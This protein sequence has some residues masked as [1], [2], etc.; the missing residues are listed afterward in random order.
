VKHK[1]LKYVY[2]KYFR[3]GVGLAIG[4]V[5][6]YLALRQVNFKDVQTA[7]LDANLACVAWSLVSVAITN[8]AKAVRWKVLLGPG[9]RNVSLSHSLM[10]VLA[11]QALNTVYPAR[12]GDVSRAYLIGGRDFDRVYALGTIIL[13]KLLDMLFYALL[14][15]L[16]LVLVP[17]PDWINS[18]IFIVA[19]IA[20][21]SLALAF[22]LAYRTDWFVKFAQV[23][24]G[25]LPQ[26]LQEKTQNW[27][28]A[29]LSSLNVL[30]SR[31]D[32]IKMAFWSTIVWAT[33]VLTNHLALLALNIQLPIAASILILIVLQVSVSL[34]SIPGRIGI[35]EYL[36]ILAL[37][38]FGIEQALSLSYGILLHVISL[39]PQTLLG[40]LFFGI[41][42]M[43]GNSSTKVRY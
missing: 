26:K 38:V 18:S 37:S 7:F 14:F 5:S 13:E 42:G 3:A 27:L 34:P 35:F 12:V 28:N 19:G 43:A 4:G 10:A 20:C 21:V 36:C 1:L 29:G 30:Q 32:L 17:L 15:F 22:I 24:I 16:L 8:L 25:W 11:G 31:L 9:G 41:L 6:L 23:P 33:A 39:L 2:S 40:L